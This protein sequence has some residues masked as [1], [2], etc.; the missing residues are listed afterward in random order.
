MRLV[1]DAEKR[2]RKLDFVQP[3]LARLGSPPDGPQW[4][5]EIKFDGYRVQAHIVKQDGCC[6]VRILTRGGHDWT[7]R[8]ASLAADLA[9]LPITSAILDGEVLATD[10]DGRTT[11]SALQAALKPGSKRKSAMTLVVFDILYRDGIDLRQK[12]LAERLAELADVLGRT[13]RRS[14]IQASV[15]LE[16]PGDDVLAR[17]CEI[18]LEGIVSKRL[19]RTYRSGRHG[20]WV[21]S[22]CARSGFFVVAGY[23]PGKSAAATVGSL[24][25]GYP[26]GERLVYVGRVGTGFTVKEAAAIW[27]GLQSIRRSHGALSGKL[28]A[29]QRRDVVWVEPVVVAE[30]LYRDLTDE[31]LLRHASFQRFRTDKSPADARP[32]AGLRIEG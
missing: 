4:V 9:R 25:L 5:H 21:K 30:V 11:F 10:Q 14:R 1:K 26:Q 15:R 17:A 27:D 3:C 8:F 6:D 20:D 24:V 12:P 19:D 13:D 16:G 7:E 22:K 18:G 23:V 29:S 2:R 32:P 31:G 28:K